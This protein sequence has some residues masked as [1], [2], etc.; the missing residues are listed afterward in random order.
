MGKCCS[1]GSCFIFLAIA[2]ALI[3]GLMMAFDGKYRVGLNYYTKVGKWADGGYKDFKDL[4][5][6]LSF[7]GGE[8]IAFKEETSTDNTVVKHWYKFDGLLG[9]ALIYVA[10]SIPSSESYN[11][12]MKT[13]IQTGGN[14]SYQRA[15]VNEK[16]V[17]IPMLATDVSN[18]PCS[19][20]ATQIGSACV[21][22]E[23]PGIVAFPYNTK[24]KSFDS[25]YA[26]S[27]ETMDI[28]GYTEDSNVTVT[29]TDLN[30]IIVSTNDPQYYAYVNNIFN[31][32]SNWKITV[33]VIV[34][35][36]CAI[37]F[38]VLGVVMLLCAF[39]SCC[40]CHPSKRVL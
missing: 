14:F 37:C 15:E 6:Q 7:P 39:C 22:I 36:I 38:F 24:S 3:S 16:A 18:L 17:N 31:L 9:K 13:I 5:F 1:C 40:C 25:T 21:K 30:A 20:G 2:L 11:V 19:D 32:T 29:F 35:P 23:T 34:L 12:P 10:G 4:S 26:T 33:I 8:N 28:S 27:Y